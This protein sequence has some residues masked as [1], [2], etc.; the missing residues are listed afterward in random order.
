M[1]L[2]TLVPT[3]MLAVLAAVAL[4][5]AIAAPST[6]VLA[7]YDTDHDKTLDLSEVKAAAA[8]HF[9]RLDKDGDHT[10]DSKE[11]VGALGP[12]AFKAAD[13]D[14]DGTV[15]KEEYLALAEKLFKGA[16]VDHDGTLS[17]DELGSKDGKAL[18]RLMG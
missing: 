5:A 6:D 9:D 3:S 10:L 1:K 16:D 14:H 15:S 2:R 17:A 13:T 18:V 7:K 4:Q 8:A 12:R 11:A